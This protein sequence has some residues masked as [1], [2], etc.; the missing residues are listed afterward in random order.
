MIK[1]FNDYAHDSSILDDFNFY[2]VKQENVSQKVPSGQE[3]KSFN[4]NIIAEKEETDNQNNIKKNNVN[5][6]IKDENKNLKNHNN[7]NSMMNSVIINQKEGD[8]YNYINN[9]INIENYYNF[10]SNNH[11]IINKMNLI[12]NQNNIYNIQQ[13][14]TLTSKGNNNYS[15]SNFDFNNTQNL[16]IE[17][18]SANQRRNLEN[19]QTSLKQGSSIEYNDKNVKFS[20]T[21]PIN[22]F[23]N[24]E[25]MNLLNSESFKVNEENQINLRGLSNDQKN[26]NG[27]PE[28]N[29]FNIINNESRNKNN[30][31][32]Q[33]H[34]ICSTNKV[35][36]SHSNESNNSYSENLEI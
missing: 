29:Y 23:Q 35:F 15:N 11:N 10:N 22:F 7:D 12:Y 24:I 5:F 26:F 9:P 4:S 32:N 34:E 3:E 17:E 31:N 16:E 8:T 13:N 6:F 36:H 18:E 14:P 21:N 30:L 28:S 1:I 20:K 19:I 2:E 27:I 25:N 33:E